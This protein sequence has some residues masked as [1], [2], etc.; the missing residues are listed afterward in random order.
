MLGEGN[1]IRLEFVYR[2]ESLIQTTGYIVLPIIEV[3]IIICLLKILYN[4]IIICFRSKA[5]VLFLYDSLFIVA[6]IIV[7][8]GAVFGPGIVIQ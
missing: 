2:A 8:G 6:L 5:V 7:C 1:S 3:C 4:T